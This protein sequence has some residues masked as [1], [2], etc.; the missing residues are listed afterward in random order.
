MNNYQSL[1]DIYDKVV[2]ENAPNAY[3]LIAQALQLVNQAIAQDLQPD[4]DSA[5]LAAKREL[6]HAETELAPR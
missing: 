2:L 3:E 1:K 6:E 5:L 4:V